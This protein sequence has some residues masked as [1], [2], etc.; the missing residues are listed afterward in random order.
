MPRKPNRQSARK[1]SSPK[2][3][4]PAKR[5]SAKGSSSAEAISLDRFDLYELCV[6]SPDY[7][8]RM[9]RAIHGGTGRS[10]PRTLGEDFCGPAAI[11]RAW[12]DLDPKHNCAVAVDRDPETLGRAIAM[13]TQKSPGDPRTHIAERTGILYILADVR[14]VRDS[15]DILCALNYSICELHSR[16]DLVRYL[17]N[18]RKRLAQSADK[19]GT[20]VCDIYAGFD[21]TLTGTT[22]RTVKHPAGHTIRYHW[23]QR[24]ANAF[25][26]IVQNAIHFEVKSSGKKEQQIRDAFVYDWRLWSIPELREAMLEAGFGTTEVYPRQADA[27]DGENNFHVMPVGDA[28]ELPDSFN[29]YVVA[30]V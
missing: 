27:I 14:V 18:A 16:E 22:S 28:A 23:Q 2:G 10:A 30:R 5:A 12:I 11:C 25:T 21:S 19:R 8:A 29:C 3:R 4:S 1:T 24:E 6:Q 26:G 7:D 20:F 13:N 9:L 15:V 17:T